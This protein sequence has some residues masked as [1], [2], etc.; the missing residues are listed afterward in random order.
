MQDYNKNYSERIQGIILEHD[1]TDRHS[2]KILVNDPFNAEI[3]IIID[4]DVW[5]KYVNYS[6]SRNWKGFLE[7]PPKNPYVQNFYCNLQDHK[8]YVAIIGEES[9][10]VWRE[11]SLNE[12][13]Q[14]SYWGFCFSRHL[15]ASYNRYQIGQICEF[16]AYAIDNN[17]RLYKP[18]TIDEDFSKYKWIYNPFTFKAEDITDESIEY[19][20][21]EIG[22]SKL[23]FDRIVQKYKSERKQLR[24]E[25]R[26]RLKQKIKTAIPKL[27]KK[28]TG[29]DNLQ[30]TLIIVTIF[31]LI[32]NIVTGILYLNLLLFP[33]KP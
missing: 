10:L 15:H 18:S 7:A 5:D 23:V 2:H 3:S 24:K 11:L 4:D 31:L 29:Y 12:I 6:G 22:I 21:A 32:T 27:W 8:F 30:K 9:N 25:G 20:I 26:Q 14:E 28:L 17:N 19:L 13:L 33:N 16:S 1:S